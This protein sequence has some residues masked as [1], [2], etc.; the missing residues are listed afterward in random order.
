[1]QGIYFEE[2]IKGKLHVPLIPSLGAW[3]SGTPNLAIHPSRI[4]TN[5]KHIPPKAASRESQHRAM[6]N[7]VN[8]GFG[9]CPLV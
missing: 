7:Q 1:M 4:N 2:E 5:P 8:R 9:L 6:I 3:D